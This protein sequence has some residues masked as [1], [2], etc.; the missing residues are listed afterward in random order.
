MIQT[1]LYEIVNFV[2]LTLENSFLYVFEISVI[3]VWCLI[4]A[5][6]IVVSPKKVQ[7]YPMI[8]I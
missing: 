4:S 7:K 3:G 6:F 5:K 1:E 8:A 2:L